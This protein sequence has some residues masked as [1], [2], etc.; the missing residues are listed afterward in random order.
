M[1][2]VGSVQHN[3]SVANPANLWVY[4]DPT[5]QASATFNFSP[6]SPVNGWASFAIE[7][8]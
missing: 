7:V 6:A 2:L 3:A 4:F 5:A 8:G 1:T